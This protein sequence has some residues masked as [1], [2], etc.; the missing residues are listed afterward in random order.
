MGIRFAIDDF[1][2]GYSSLAYLKRLP[3]DAIKIDKSFVIN[4]IENQNDAVIVRSTID[5]A[6]NLGLK[7]IAEG[8]EQ[9]GIW[10]RLSDLGCDAAQGYF[11]SKPIPA[12]ECTRWLHESPW[13]LKQEVHERS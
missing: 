1:G 5:L 9:Q 12:D 8:V 4:M 11:V 13:G 2:I 3:V 6:H 7:V 10:D